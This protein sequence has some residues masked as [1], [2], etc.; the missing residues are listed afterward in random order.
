MTDLLTTRQVQDILKVD[1]ITI[2]RM[3]QDGRLKG[4]KVGSQWRF[5]TTEV[6]RLLSGQSQIE[7]VATESAAVFPVHCVQTIQNLLS[8]VSLMSALVLDANGDP[9][10][11]YSTQTELSRVVMGS[12][13]GLEAY[14]AAWHRFSAQPTDAFECPAGLSSVAAPI[15]VR[16]KTVGWFLVGQVFLDAAATRNTEKLTTQFGAEA[17]RIAAAILSVPVVT[18]EQWNLMKDWAG[19]AAQAVESILRERTSFMLRLQQIADLTQLK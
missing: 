3:L 14:Q 12:P 9:V 13:D 5:T 18:D 7:A 4:V 10:T 11:E 17:G 2:Y 15:A 16:G 1:R 19:K 8:G 6:E